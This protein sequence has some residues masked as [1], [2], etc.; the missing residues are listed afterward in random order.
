MG[1]IIYYDFRRETRRQEM[2]EIQDRASKRLINF[3]NN[4]DT[5]TNDGIRKQI[6]EDN[7]RL[8]ELEREERKWGGRLQWEESY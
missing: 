4:P 1:K 6:R 3:I 5:Y 8:L 7:L 2:Q